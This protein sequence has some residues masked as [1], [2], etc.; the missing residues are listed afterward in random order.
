MK[1]YIRMILI[2]TF[3]TLGAPSWSEKDIETSILSEEDWKI[4]EK[5]RKR[6][7]PGGRDEDDLKIMSSATSAKRKLN[8]REIEKEVFKQLFNEDLKQS[9]EDAESEADIE[10]E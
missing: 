5:A 3:V 1:F 2:G 7:Y 8:R 4:Q 9:A 10:E 6:L